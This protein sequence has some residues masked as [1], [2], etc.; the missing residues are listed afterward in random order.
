[1]GNL[2]P[3][4]NI[5]IFPVEQ[6]GPTSA[7][8]QRYAGG[9]VIAVGAIYARYAAR[10]GLWAAVRSTWLTPSWAR[11]TRTFRHRALRSTVDGYQRGGGAG[12]VSDKVGSIITVFDD[13]RT[14]K[15]L[16]GAKSRPTA[17]PTRASTPATR[18]S[19]HTRMMKQARRILARFPNTPRHR[20]AAGD[21]A[22]VHSSVGTLPSLRLRP[23]R[24]ARRAGAAKAVDEPGSGQRRPR[25]RFLQLHRRACSWSLKSFTGRCSK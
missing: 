11:S 5:A 2:A 6:F 24:R 13:Y 23:Q 18:S 3:Y 20:F 12:F 8:L 21:H 7:V 15:Y 1:M 10:E 4:S 9:R 25:C 19:D 14:S 17:S 16:W 22:P